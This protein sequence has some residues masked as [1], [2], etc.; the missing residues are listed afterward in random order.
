MQ[1]GICH[2]SIV[3]LRFIASNQSEM[4]SQVLYGE[5][6]KVL[7]ERASWSRI[8]L[9]FD[10]FEAWINNKQYRKLEEASYFSLI[11]QR[12]RLSVDLVEYITDENGYLMPIPLGA[13]LNNC[14]NFSHIFEGN[15]IDKIQ[16]KKLLIHSA[17]LY[18]NTPHCWGGRSPFGMDSS[19][20]TQMVYKLN[21]Y[22]LFRSATDQAK[23]GEPLS[24]IEES[25]PGDLVF[26]DD[27]DGIINHVGIMMEDNYI[28]HSDGQVRIDRIDHSG[29]FN[30]ELRKHTHKLRVIKKII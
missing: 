4:L 19:G 21:G 27:N 28:I 20:F 13:T 18:L 7:E 24:F 9:S 8:R 2:L 30:T 12:P 14:D 15:F 1:Y 29:I 5:H 6:F 3:P 11:E 22:Q 26:F 17:L 10:N 16:P 25:E 23:Q